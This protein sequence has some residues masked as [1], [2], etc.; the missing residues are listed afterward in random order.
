[1]GLA[2]YLNPRGADFMTRPRHPS[3]PPSASSSLPSLLFVFQY[4]FLLWY[5]TRGRSSTP[6]SFQGFFLQ[7][8]LRRRVHPS[9]VVPEGAICGRPFS[10][11]RHVFPLF[12][13]PTIFLYVGGPPFFPGDHTVFSR[14]GSG[15]RIFLFPKQSFTGRSLSC[16]D[17]FLSSPF[18]SPFF[19]CGRK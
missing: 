5:R 19:F 15:R 8:V 4:R 10:G 7:L 6:V 9:L 2:F 13:S 11:F 1:V 14:R 3:L 17:V 12:P 18:P 16:F